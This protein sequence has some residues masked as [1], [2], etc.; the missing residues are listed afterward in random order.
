MMQ[1]DNPLNTGSISKSFHQILYWAWWIGNPLVGKNAFNTFQY[2]FFGSDILASLFWAAVLWIWRVELWSQ[3]LVAIW[4]FDIYHDPG[5]WQCP[6]KAAGA[7]HTWAP[8][9]PHQPGHRGKW[10]WHHHQEEE[11]SH[12]NVRLTIMMRDCWWP[13]T[14]DT[15][16]AQG[17]LPWCVQCPLSAGAEMNR[18]KTS[19]RRGEAINK[20]IIWSTMENQIISQINMSRLS[21][22]GIHVKAGSCVLNA[23]ANANIRKR[24]F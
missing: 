7:P 8:P 3:V 5:S 19:L 24:Y 16:P 10:G 1:A 4:Q 14:E 9:A 17:S 6:N 11:G 18:V 23:V 20:L 21:V 22:S 2:P 15:L 12:N 13:R